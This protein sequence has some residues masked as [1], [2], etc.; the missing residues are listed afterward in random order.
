MLNMSIDLVLTP[1]GDERSVAMI[2]PALE[3]TSLQAVF[4]DNYVAL[5]LQLMLHQTLGEESKWAA[6]AQDA[7]DRTPQGALFWTEVGRF[8]DVPLSLLQ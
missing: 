2:R 5:T 1:L 6:I 8:H 7:L 4:G 3:E